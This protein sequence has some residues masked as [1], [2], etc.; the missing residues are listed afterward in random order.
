MGTCE[1]TVNSFYSCLSHEKLMGAKCEE[2]GIHIIP[3]RSI[4][5]QCGSSNLEWFKSSGEGILQTIT[6]IHIP[7]SSLADKAPYVV[8]IVKVNEGPSIMG[9]ITNIDPHNIEQIK[10]GIKVR[11]APFKE[12]NRWILAFKPI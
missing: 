7:L 11:F 12:R 2:C 9:R 3:P 6:V 5:F 8:G 10:L 4:C 1:F